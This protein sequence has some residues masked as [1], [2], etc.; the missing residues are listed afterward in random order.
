MKACDILSKEQV[1]CTLIQLFLFTFFCFSIF[2]W[3]AANSESW[4]AYF[5][6]WSQ[7]MCQKLLFFQ[8]FWPVILSCKKGHMTIIGSYFGLYLLFSWNVLMN[9]SDYNRSE[10]NTRRSRCILLI[11]I[12]KQSESQG[13][14]VSSLIGCSHAYRRVWEQSNKKIW[15]FF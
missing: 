7:L 10:Q 6:F 4:L 5:Y 15:K 12:S 13:N 14:R 2:S 9:R 11:I 8:Q 3:V 1:D